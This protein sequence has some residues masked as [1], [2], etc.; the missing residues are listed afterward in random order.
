MSF[1]RDAQGKL[2]PNTKK[3]ASLGSQ[4]RVIVSGGNQ[5]TESVVKKLMLDVVANLSA[6]PQE[7]GTPVDTG[8]ARANWLP[9]V[10]ASISSP[11]GSREDN[12]E[13]A[14]AAKK[15]GLTSVLGYRLGMGNVYVTNNVPYILKLNDGHSGQAASGF[16]Q[17]AIIKA[18]AGIRT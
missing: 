2:V 4:I 7:G 12:V 15:I 1:D 10:G 17:A 8:W 3:G 13:G 11:A 18:V 6:A 14:V 5:V 9:S 16:V